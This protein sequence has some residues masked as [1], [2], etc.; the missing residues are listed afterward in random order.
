MT[1]KKERG[2]EQEE[3]D[4]PN[5]SG[6]ADKNVKMKHLVWRT[7]GGTVRQEYPGTSLVVPW[8]GHA[9]KAGGLGSILVK[10]L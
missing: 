8:L 9:P 10:G 4:T 7:W 6:K 1:P 3:R 5:R 2:G